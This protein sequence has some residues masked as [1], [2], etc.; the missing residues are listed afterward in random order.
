MSLYNYAK[1]ACSGSDEFE[2]ISSVCRESKILDLDAIFLAGSAI[3]V[4]R[5]V[6]VRVNLKKK[7]K[8]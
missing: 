4:E 5:K 8:S 2:G 7:F 1:Y 6:N 3:I